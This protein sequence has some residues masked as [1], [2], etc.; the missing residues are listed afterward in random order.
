MRHDFLNLESFDQIV[1]IGKVSINDKVS[2]MLY[3][4]IQFFSTKSNAKYSNLLTYNNFQTEMPDVP[5]AKAHA[6]I[7]NLL[8]TNLILQLFSYQYNENSKSLIF[9]PVFISKPKQSSSSVF[10]MYEELVKES[11]KNVSQFLQSK[12]ESIINTFKTNLLNDADITR[13]GKSDIVVNS[14]DNINIE[15]Y[16]VIPD[17]N[18][19]KTELNDIKDILTKN[20]NA[21]NI[22]GYGIFPV[23][24]NQV[25]EQYNIMKDVFNNKIIP[26]Y[27]NNDIFMRSAKSISLEESI[28]DEEKHKP[29]TSRFTVEKAKSLSNAMALKDESENKN[30]AGKLTVEI[31]LKLEKIIEKKLQ[32]NWYLEKESIYN[33]IKNKIFDDNVRWDKLIIFYDENEKNNI[34]ADVWEKLTTD[35]DILYTK[36]HKSK[37]IIHAFLRKNDEAISSLVNNMILLPATDYWKIL[38]LKTFIENAE[39]D[40]PE[41]FRNKTFA[42]Q[43]GKLLR[44][45][46]IAFMPVFM[47]MLFL[48]LVPF[49]KDIAFTNA[50]S[51]IKSEQ[52]KFEKNNNVYFYKKQEELKSEKDRKLMQIRK[53]NLK[54]KILENLDVHYLGNSFSLPNI[55]TIQKYIPNISEKEFENILREQNFVSMPVSQNKENNYRILFY[56]K[57]QNFKKYANKIITKIKSIKESN[58]IDS[59]TPEEADKVVSFLENEMKKSMTSQPVVEED[60]YKKFTKELDKRKYEKEMW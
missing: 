38:I 39:I 26:S 4:K 23:Y 47:R 49:F 25:I 29:N 54:N 24:E 45:S 34:P 9:N 13:T 10:D 44:K 57:D 15:K 21:L 8:D 6:A 35:E 40:M 55:L 56:P 5:A 37:K 7:K 59:I 32:E 43:Y 22:S 42:K 30:Y 1:S 27:K 31:L 60:P 12:S 52:K 41:L 17:E 2:F 48:Y 50:K 14:L 19:L 28:Y 33:E 36:W 51:K 58:N 11:A 18:I 3:Q 20:E 46:Y 53:L 16:E